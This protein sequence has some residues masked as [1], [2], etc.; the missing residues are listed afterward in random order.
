M[1]SMRMWIYQVRSLNW[2]R[3]WH[4]DQQSWISD[5]QFVLPKLIHQFYTEHKIVLCVCR[6]MFTII[7]VQSSLDVSN[8]IVCFLCSIWCNAICT[9]H[10]TDKNKFC[11]TE[12]LIFFSLPQTVPTS[13][14]RTT[15]CRYILCGEKGYTL[16]SAAIVLHCMHGARCGV[17]SAIQHLHVVA[18][19]ALWHLLSSQPG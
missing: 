2:K 12:Q 1:W 3:M 16:H 19:H 11:L 10:G 7:P 18:Q 13:S 6:C 15:S 14:F 17:S 4:M 9:W 8:T 5:F